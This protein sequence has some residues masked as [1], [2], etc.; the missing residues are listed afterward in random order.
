MNYLQA[1]SLFKQTI[2]AF[3]F[4]AIG[5]L[6]CTQSYAQAYKPAGLPASKLNVWLD[7]GDTTKTS[8]S[9]GVLTWTDKIN[10]IAFT[11]PSSTNSP[12]K[13]T[14]NGKNIIDFDGFHVLNTPYN[15]LFEPTNGYNLAQAAYVFSDAPYTDINITGGGGS[16]A[17]ASVPFETNGISI[18]SVGSG[19]GSGYTSAP[20]VTISGGP[21]TGATATATISGGKVTAITVTNPGSGYVS[22]TVTLTGG[23][24]TTPATAT[25]SA[26]TCIGNTVTIINGGSGYTSA[27]TISF[28]GGS[29][30]TG[31][32]TISGGAVTAITINTYGGGMAST[33]LSDARLGLFTRTLITP[34]VP[35]IT[36]DYNTSV[37]KYTS[38]LSGSSIT[39]APFDLRGNW[40]LFENNG[41]V[42]VSKSFTATAMLNG[43]Y[44]ITNTSAR[45]TNY[46]SNS[47]SIG[48]R[49]TYYTNAFVHWGIGETVLTNLS[50]GN[51]GRKIL[52]SYLAWK[53]GQ[54][55]N[56]PSSVLNLYDPSN[57]SFS[58]NIV[59]IGYEG[60]TDSISSTYTNDGMGITSTGFLK[61]S[62]D[63][64]IAAHNGLTGTSTIQT[65][66]TR[67]NRVWY[68]SKEDL[69][70]QGGGLNMFFDFTNMGITLD[71][72]D[73]YYN[74]LYNATDPTF[75]TGTNIFVP[76][77]SYMQNP[78]TS[79]LSFA[80]NASN[81]ATGYYTIVYTP[82]A[83]TSYPTTPYAPAGFPL[84]KF[85]LWFDAS[86]QTTITQSA[87]VVTKWTDKAN[88]LQATPTSSSYDPVDTT[89]NGKS[90]IE[91]RGVENLNIPDNALL[92]PSN[93]YHLAQSVFVYSDAPTT[94]TDSRLGTYSRD[95]FGICTPEISVRYITADNKYEGGLTPNN[96]GYMD[97]SMSDLRNNWALL[98]NYTLSGYTTS[99]AIVDGGQIVSGAA[100]YVN[101][102]NTVTLGNRNTSPTSV[103][104]G[105]GETLLTGN[106]VGNSGR[107]IIGSYLSAKWG[108][109]AN[110]YTTQLSLY[111]P[112]SDSNTTFSNDL[113]GIGS[114]GGTDS[115]N[116]TSTTN[117]LGISNVMTTSG[118]L[119][120]AGDFLVAA[121]NGL[122]GTATIGTSFTRW[123]RVWYLS[124]NDA[125]GYGGDVNLFFDFAQYGINGLVNTLTESYYILYNPHDSTFASGHN[126][127][128]PVIS[129]QKNSGT[130]Q[131]S[132][133]L[134]VVNLSNGYYTIVYGNSNVSTSNIPYITT[135]TPPTISVSPA[136]ILS[137]ILAGDKVNY[138]SWNSD[139]IPY[140]VAYYKIYVSINGGTTTLIDSVTAPQQYYAHYNVTNGS[141]YNYTVTAVF[142]PGKESIQSN[143][144]TGVPGINVPV[145]GTTPQYAGSGKVFMAGYT[146]NGVLPLKF[147]FQCVT[148]GTTTPA[149]VSLFYTDSLLTNGNTYQ[150][151]YRYMD[152]VNTNDTSAWSTVIT[153]TLA[154]S[155]R[156]GFTYNLTYLDNTTIN[157]PWGIGPNA[158]NPLNQD[159]VGLRFIEN[160]PPSYTHPRIYCNPEDST[161]IKWN[162]L[163][164]YS[165]I[166][167]A[168]FTHAYTT[169]LQLGYSKY[170][171]TAYYNKD[172]MGVYYINNT[173][174]FDVSSYYD[175]LAAGDTVG[176]HNLWGGHTDLMAYTFSMEAFECWLYKG[177]ID[178]TTGTSYTT[179]AA[180][181]SAA[182]S[183]MA[184]A[185]L[186]DPNPANQLSFAN[187]DRL[188]G[189][190]MALAYDFIYSQMSV[191][192]QDTMR[193]A[194]ALIAADSADLHGFV[195][196][197]YSYTSNWATFGY[198]II[199]NLVI[200]N[201]TGYTTSLNNG[202]KNWARSVWNFLT[203]G[204]YE[205]TGNFREANGKDQ[206]NAALLVAMAKRGYS[207]LGHPSVRANAHSYYPAVTQPFGYSFLGTDLLGG[208]G[209]NVG[210]GFVG[211]TAT[212]GWRNNAEDIMGLKWAYPYD[213]AVDFVW[214][215]YIQKPYI[216]Y[217]LTGSPTLINN[218]Y[219]YPLMNNSPYTYFNYNIPSLVFASNYFPTAFATEAQSAL[220][221]LMYFDS[222]GG[223]ATLRSG[224]DSLAATL[225]Y[226]NRQD[227]G[228]HTYSNKNDIVYSALGRIM[229][230]RV[231]TSSNNQFNQASFTGGSSGILIN[232][233]GAY[234]DTATFNVGYIPPA[235]IVYYNNSP[236][237]LSIAGQAKESYSN[238][239][240]SA[241]GGYQGD[242]P[243][244]YVPGDSAVTSSPNS[245]RYSPYF[246]EDNDEYYNT[247]C[248]NDDS[249]ATPYSYNRFVKTPYYPIQEIYRTVAMVQY[250]QPYVLIADDAQMN[251]STN[252]YQWVAQIAQD[253]SISSTV[254]N[255]VDTNYRNDIIFS[256]PSFRGNRRFLVRV[257]NNTGEVNPNTG[258][259]STAVPGI[260]DSVNT[261]IH[262]RLRI[263]S[264][265]VNPH[266]KIMLF[267]YNSNDST[268]QTKWNT[269]MDTLQV[270]FAD[271]I[272]TFAF[273]VDSTG[274][275]NIN[276]VSTVNN[277][278]FAKPHVAT[279]APETTSAFRKS[280]FS[281]GVFPNPVS[282]GNMKLQFQNLDLGDYSVNIYSSTGV[283]VKQTLVSH[284]GGSANYPMAT[285]FAKGIY[286]VEVS[287]NCK[288]YSEKIV[289]Q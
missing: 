148:N 246:S 91:F 197:S 172:T 142:A 7:A 218:Y 235:T 75:A 186:S 39:A 33:A 228:G 237:M 53:W 72:V 262:H 60:G 283:L 270:A 279:V 187:R 267:A 41:T 173:G 206:L 192:Q 179:R 143:N 128:I 239:W 195:T 248:F 48:N 14:Q 161:S 151:K 289:V 74:I 25:T 253:L 69:G 19:G 217:K 185:L 5:T 250:S 199:P 233:N 156:G 115:I 38:T 215:N 123:N 80:V 230:D 249:I 96:S 35:Q 89:Q 113:V 34:N 134:D 257:L 20:T 169:L 261:L 90:I 92:D 254:V 130:N 146:P 226:A 141:S 137:S 255:L 174:A 203:Y 175:S 211:D 224:F 21:G 273:V 46:V 118:F 58:N 139:S 222:L 122:T 27:P 256:E 83:A 232:G 135:L 24:Y 23:G 99:N 44:S 182:M 240:L 100:H 164:T 120:Q 158:L 76:Y 52:E 125:S 131:M 63:Y 171:K 129:Y 176:Y 265:S 61:D 153:L 29:N 165:G 78:G 65:D 103:H 155:A 126:Y 166:A 10:G 210:S 94:A 260:I 244:L 81:V 136:P 73:N 276:L 110:L 97:S 259:A 67:W 282:N 285:P 149:Q 245:F 286:I 17:V 56:L 281:V 68:L 162:L 47:I 181:L 278:G 42:P 98:Q 189:F 86:D 216:G 95:T 221:N 62:G 70:T 208:T 177:T 109:Q 124:K 2:L 77:T 214:K 133:L 178:V 16:G 144:L 160:V 229:I 85:N 138:I 66:F 114:E 220:G 145:W 272:K 264:K 167:S 202:V 87:G 55:A 280:A 201:E 263:E 231:N 163:N 170:S 200:E 93:G 8:I 271:S 127:I 225:F 238:E 31:T 84:S 268:P 205:Q 275:T 22:P 188:G 88:G 183:T 104:W 106:D 274:R 266:F 236:S 6:F 213:T 71:T 116:A 252:D 51:S 121:D 117:G 212:G 198:E 190:N 223:F 32:A 79:Q 287:G 105:I 15:A 157:A 194:L 204:V 4:A 251:S 119:R 12:T 26:T 107:M 57:T 82:K 207:F 269:T 11:A 45:D 111:S 140:A 54:Q 3:L 43:T 30:P 242:N 49:N 108:M 241:F 13:S 288:R 168:K 132:F 191:N 28:N 9:S 150:F 184:R 1:R 37:S 64:I 219:C 40:S 196:P 247:L 159:T 234:T 154:D 18:I 101:K 180:K 227:M 36:A 277:M 284:P 59:G 50:L 193:M 209:I 147:V 112:H 152:S 243:C 258:L 102:T